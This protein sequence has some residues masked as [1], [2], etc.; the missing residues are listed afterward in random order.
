M[1]QDRDILIMADWSKVVHDLSNSAVY[2]DLEWS[3]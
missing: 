3:I 1:V 2:S